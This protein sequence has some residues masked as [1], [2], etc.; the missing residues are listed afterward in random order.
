M[1]KFLTTV[2]KLPVV[3]EVGDI[4]Q[5]SFVPSHRA[6]RINLTVK[7]TGEVRVAV[8]KRASLKDA[9]R[10][11]LSKRE[12]IKRQFNR[13][14]GSQS[15]VDEYAGR[16][17]NLDIDKAAAG[18]AERLREI[19]A[20]FG[21]SYNRL[22]IRNQKTRWGSCSMKNNL[23]LNIKLAL[24]P[25]ELRDFILVHELAH[26][27]IK[28]HGPAFWQ[29]LESIYPNARE[30]DKQINRLGALLRIPLSQ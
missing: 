4:G 12:W 30:L 10:F 20:K 28:N 13:L 21:F 19:A 8:P 16:I 29:K 6:R 14:E 7:V 24:L 5:V 23:S 11:V 15:V 22:T 27:E 9:E 1:K 17:E 26:T 25:G 3:K 2:K 18:I